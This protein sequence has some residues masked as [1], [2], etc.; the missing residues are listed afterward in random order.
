MFSSCTVLGCIAPIIFAYLGSL[1]APRDLTVR[2][3]VWT[4]PNLSRHSGTKFL[5]EKFAK[6]S[7]CIFLNVFFQCN[8]F[9]S[10]ATPQC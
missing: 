9:L 10:V 3:D 2:D 8:F 7:L 1:A 6:P 4:L 5:Y